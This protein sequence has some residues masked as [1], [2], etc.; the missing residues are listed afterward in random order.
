LITNFEE[1][2]SIYWDICD[3]ESALRYPYYYDEPCVIDSDQFDNLKKVQHLLFKSFKYFLPRYEQ[4]DSIIEYSEKFKKI[5]TSFNLEETR[6]GFYRP[7]FV[8][9]ETGKI[10]ICELGCRYYEAYWGH[11]ISEF[12]MEKRNKCS[13]QENNRSRIIDNVIDHA[14][15]WWSGLEDSLV[16]LKGRDREGDIR[17]YRPFFEKIG[18]TLHYIYPDTIADN[19]HLLEQRPVLNA[20][21]QMEIE[22]LTENEIHAISK[23]DCLNPLPTVLL[24]HD[25]RFLAVLWDDEFRDSA[26]G[27]MDSSFLKEYLIP[28]YTRKQSKD[29]WTYAQNNK[30]EFIL[31]PQLLGKSEG[32]IPGPLVSEL[33]WKSAFNAESIKTM[34]L[35][36]WINQ[37]EFNASIDGKNFLDYGTGMLLCMEDEFYGP[38]QFRMSSCEVI[39]YIKDDRKMAPWITD[40]ANS[41]HGPYFTLD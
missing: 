34:I 10:K 39:N 19:L 28:T 30:D 31:K 6:I 27:K 3:E 7:D 14:F 5:V 2:K 20:F 4:Y 36:R 24:L 13:N 21:S 40:N 38:G 22:A 26:L 12:I 1:A 18:V 11:G 16:I 41:Y 32:I 35:Q 25:K 9:P 23:S 8:I 29:L 33:E 17:F 15:E 37:K